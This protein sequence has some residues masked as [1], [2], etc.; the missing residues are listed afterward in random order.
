MRKIGILLICALMLAV[1][2]Q[3]AHAQAKYPREQTLYYYIDG[4]PIACPDNFN[5]YNIFC[6][7]HVLNQYVMEHLFYLP[8]YSGEFIPG[9]NYT[10]GDLIPW[11]AEKYE[12]SSDFR[13]VTIYLRRGVEWSDGKPFTAEDVAFTYNMLKEHAPDLGYSTLAAEWIE[14]V[15][16]L[17]TYVI[18]FTLT[19]PNPRILRTELFTPMIWGAVA[20]VPKHIWEGQDPITFTNNP[21]VFT[22]PYKLVEYSS[23]GDYFVW[24]RRDDWWG[25]KVFGIR[26][27]PKYVICR[28]YT[29]EEALIMEAAR[30]MQDVLGYVSVGGFLRLREINPYVRSWY[31]Q[32]P[33]AWEEVCPGY[34][35]IN[36]A[37]Y[38]WNRKEVRCALSYAINR[39]ALYEVALEKTALPIN[40][41]FPPYMMPQFTKLVNQMGSKYHADE[42]NPA[43]AEELLLGLGWK[44]GPDGIWVTENGTRVKAIAL[45]HSGWLYIKKWGLQVVDQLREFGIDAIPKL[46]EGPAFWDA[47]NTGAWD[48]APAYWICESVDE[49]YATLDA[50]HSKYVTP[51]GEL[52]LGGV[53][54]NRWINKTYDEIID[55]IAQMSPVDPRYL[56]LVERALE[57]W[58]QELPAIPLNAQPALIAFNSYYWTGWPSADNP[59]MQPYYQCASFRF[60]LFQLKPTKIDY[61]IVY[62]TKETPK[63]RGIDLVW[64]GSFKAGESARIPVDDAEF[65][66]KKGYASLTPPITP[67]TGLEDIS[68]KLDEVS[69]LLKSM[70]AKIESLSSNIV[71]VSG[72]LTGLIIAVILEAIAIIVFAFR[73]IRRKTE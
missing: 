73:L 40:N 21:P 59:Y 56:G 69:S 33:Y 25:T 36:C 9:F 16:V 28:A 10:A 65:W 23:T 67:I 3:S 27:G 7:S 29:S 12:M 45:I 15:E 14:E 60:I 48:I 30:N 8:Y 13:Q 62:F 38:P 11:L 64:Y 32:P 26:P 41:L 18:R 63:L 47:L 66:I 5:P 70:D 53:G 49:P 1:L 71:T 20:P 68:A 37:K 52:P 31:D 34:M 51:L 61:T 17:N 35:P 50:F 43:K 2:P 54:F 39:T 22:G 57:I 72:S 55:Q 19:K 58:Y 42:Y 6:W 24:E 44:K 4:G 46:L